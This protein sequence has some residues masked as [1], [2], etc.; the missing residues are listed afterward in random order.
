MELCIIRTWC[1]FNRVAW[2]A[3]KMAI[4]VAMPDVFGTA[5]R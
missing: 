1:G 4:C 5:V 3:D 2:L